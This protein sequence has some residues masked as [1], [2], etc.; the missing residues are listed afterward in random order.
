MKKFIMITPLQPV[1]WDANGQI[2][3]DG[4]SKCIYEAVG[5]HLLAMNKPTRFPLLSVIN[6]Y[7][8]KGEEIQVIS[9][10]PKNKSSYVHLDQLR[11]EFQ[12][13]REEKGFICEDITSVEV[14]Y[15]GDV[16]TQIEIFYKLLP[17]I[18]DNDILYGCLTYGVKP[19]PIAE[20]M[21]IQYGY[22]VLDNV[23][24]G[25]LVYGEKDHSAPGEPTRIFDITALIQL[26]EIVRILADR[27]VKNPE[28]IIDSVIGMRTREDL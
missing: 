9:I 3:R 21:A 27:K 7:A 11:S 19:M 22:R 15:A 14:T 10:T 28:K 25:C 24:I 8:E 17:Y 6:A 1:K 12:E 26:D 2:I 23:T 4:L 16:D 18:Q 5:N 13:L 20:L